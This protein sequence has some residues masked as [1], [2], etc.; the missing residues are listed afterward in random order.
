[1]AIQKLLRKIP[2]AS[3]PGIDEM[4]AN[5][6]FT[7]YTQDDLDRFEEMLIQ[8]SEDNCKDMIRGYFKV[9]S[10]LAKRG[11]RDGFFVRVVGVFRRMLH[12]TSETAEKHEESAAAPSKK[13]RRRSSAGIS[14]RIKREDPTEYKAEIVEDNTFCENSTNTCASHAIRKSTANDFESTHLDRKPNTERQRRKISYGYCPEDLVGKPI[15]PDLF[16]RALNPEY[17]FIPGLPKLVLGDIPTDEEDEYFR[18]KEYMSSFS[19]EYDEKCNFNDGKPYNCRRCVEK[20]YVDKMEGF[21][22]LG[23]NSGLLGVV[24]DRECVHSDDRK[25]DE[26][27]SSQEKRRKI[28]GKYYVDWVIE[29]DMSNAEHSVGREGSLGA[30]RAYGNCDATDSVLDKADAA[31]TERISA[32]DAA[33]GTDGG[34]KGTVVGGDLN[35]TSDTI[36]KSSLSGHF[37]DRIGG[38]NKGTAFDAETSAENIQPS[39]KSTE[40][41]ENTCVYG[42]AEKSASKTTPFVLD[43]GVSNKKHELDASFVTK[44]MQSPQSK[45]PY[46]C[47]T[48]VET[49]LEPEFSKRQTGQKVSLLSSSADVSKSEMRMPHILIPESF[50]E[51]P[52]G[53]LPTKQ[54]TSSSYISSTADD[55]NMDLGVNMQ[56]IRVELPQALQNITETQSSKELPSIATPYCWNSAAAAY[57]N[58]RDEHLPAKKRDLQTMQSHSSTVN[59]AAFALQKDSQP[60]MPFSYTQE[61]PLAN[62]SF[63]SISGT[64]KSPFSPGIDMNAKQESIHSGHFAEKTH[65]TM[66]S[67]R[68]DVPSF[69][70]IFE[71]NTPSAA[72]DQPLIPQGNLFGSPSGEASRTSREG[73]DV[74][75]RFNRRKR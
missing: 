39:F 48:S 55:K 50:S 14:K 75:S 54:N 24:T 28:E 47:T 31:V 42:S 74:A 49:T 17:N 35:N 62:A 67:A 20:E 56:H 25:R 40:M 72:N 63:L 13:R 65:G 1:M 69:T 34:N 58:N 61:G 10:S 32:G 52:N 36:A 51:V 22:L 18:K 11:S 29:T 3:K 38:D 23:G 8:N 60:S 45:A 4:L 43:N 30:Q 19:D 9:L 59:S 46:S 6:D 71:A 37:S 27:H 70:N 33:E 57:K 21:G 44:T 12:N 64:V 15:S 26:V 68:Q 73:Q 16:T 2:F 7:K 5:D 41:R 66:E 53:A